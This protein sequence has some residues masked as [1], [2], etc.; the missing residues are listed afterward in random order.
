MGYLGLSRK[1]WGVFNK[2]TVN[3]DTTSHLQPR[4]GGTLNTTA[5]TWTNQYQEVGVNS[6]QFCR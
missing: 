5:I 3:A 1:A 6:T 4:L 2:D